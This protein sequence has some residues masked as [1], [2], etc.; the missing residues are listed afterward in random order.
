MRAEEEL[1]VLHSIQQKSDLGRTFKTSYE[2]NV[3]FI[4]WMHSRLIRKFQSSRLIMETG[5]WLWSQQNCTCHKRGGISNTNANIYRGKKSG[6]I[7]HLMHCIDFRK[8]QKKFF[9]SRSDSTWHDASVGAHTWHH[10]VNNAK[11]GGKMDGG[12]CKVECCDGITQQ[13]FGVFFD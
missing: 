8:F 1:L 6:N 5:G 11:N 4:I 13:H 7:E 2:S 12:F 3:N 10:N 9:E